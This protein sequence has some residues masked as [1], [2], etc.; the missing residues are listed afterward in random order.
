[1]EHKVFVY[2]TLRR[3]QRNFP[4]LATSKFIGDAETVEQFGMF[5]RDYPFVTSLVQQT[6]IAGEIYEVDD[7]TLRRL[8]QLE[9]HPKFYQRGTAHFT[10]ENEVPVEAFIYLFNRPREHFVQIGTPEILNGDFVDPIFS[11]DEE[12][13]LFYR[14]FVPYRY[15]Y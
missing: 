8:D 9:G 7:K 4:L 2:G 10:L 12:R 3:G 1:M 6:E 15:A 11:S 13:D 5:T 14:K